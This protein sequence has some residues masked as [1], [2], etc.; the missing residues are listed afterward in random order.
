[1]NLTK[2]FFTIILA[3]ILIS[4]GKSEKKMAAEKFQIANNLYEM[5][6]TIEALK[7]L[8]VIQT[9]YK[10]ALQSYDKANKLKKKIYAD[11]FYR[12]QDEM[13]SLNVQLERLELK[14]I[15]EKTQFDRYTQYIH[16]RQQHKRRWNKSFIQVHLDERGDLYISSNYY[17]AEWLNH[18]GLRVY[19]NDIQ[20]K[21]EKIATD[22]VLNH[23]SDFLETKWE[24][25]SFR[26]GKDNGVMEFIAQNAERNLKAV[27]LGSRY[28]YIVLE[29]YDKQAVIDALALSKIL[30]QKIKL[31]HE[32][33]ALQSEV[34]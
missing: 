25:V 11:V 2:V 10:G 29:E 9:N 16:K 1:M 30:K 34:G 23:H 33:K 13:D 28:Y 20:A 22:N 31:S 3:T 15:Q 19:D 8:E 26:D 4:C 6:D 32:I 7:Q 12:K 17:G 5:G 21:T 24:K 14:F 18:T 27:F